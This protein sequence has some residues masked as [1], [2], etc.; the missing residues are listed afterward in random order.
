M[1]R[2]AGG[3]DLFGGTLIRG[4]RDTVPA[5][6]R[7]PPVC[8]IFDLDQTLC[9]IG[10]PIVE[11]VA[12]QLRQ[13]SACGIPVAICSGKPIF[14]LCGL[15]R[16]L[17]LETA[18]LIG[19]NG[20][21][22]QIG[23]DL[24]PS[25]LW[26]HQVT[27][28][29]RRLLTEI[30]AELLER[31]GARIWLQPNE[32]QVTP[33]FADTATGREVGA[34]LEQKI[35]ARPE[36]EIYGAENCYD[37]VPTGLD[38]GSAVRALGAIL[39][40]PTERMISVGDGF[41]D[42][43]LF[44]VTGL[45]IGIATP[46]NC[47]VTIRVDDIMTAIRVVR[48]K[49]EQEA[50]GLLGRSLDDCRPDDDSAWLHDLSCRMIDGYK[51]QPE[52]LPR[53][54]DAAPDRR[55]IIQLIDLW[56]QLLFPGYFARCNF[57]SAALQ[58][59]TAGLL[60]R[61]ERILAREVRAALMHVRVGDSPTE[62]GYAQNTNEVPLEL[63]LRAENIA[64]TFM[65]RLPEVRAMLETDVLATRSGDPAAASYSEVI[66]SY[67]GI[68][69]IMVHRLA[70]ELYKLEVPMIPRIMSE[71]AHSE[72][73]ID[74]HPGAQ[75]GSYFM[76]DHGTGVVIGETCVIGSRVKI[77]QGVTLGALSTRKVEQ[78]RRSKR[79]PTVE[80]DVTIYG[81]ATILG[82]VT[83]GAGATI[84]G[85]VFITESIAAGARVS[86]TETD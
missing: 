12:L 24:P 64:R 46:E 15:A 57:S 59:Q 55:A 32:L 38:K 3:C 39:D 62:T 44:A 53:R 4:D 28:E 79:H 26:A 83:I 56:R 37:I 13:F 31:F 51:R 10:A 67:P 25:F 43:P 40:C 17:G 72:T 16:Q 82:T 73:G 66:L 54:T 63:R 8:L 34:F 78:L 86:L 27:S 42:Y 76:I 33:F 71:Y 48:E 5:E 80:D 75:I 2:Q 70:H 19:E 30:G 84:G 74:I 52:L 77:Y 35:A 7:R 22:L 69:A 18:L 68:F 45:S 11:E 1:E 50:P 36:L 9:D 14:Y 21:F 58:A 65:Q 23:L 47:P 49:I 29:Q 85:N 61:I 41:N 6:L 60:V 20:A 81:G